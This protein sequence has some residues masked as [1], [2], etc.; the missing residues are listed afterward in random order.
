MPN[1]LRLAL[2]TPVHDD[3]PIFV[4]GN[5][6]DWH[7]AHE[8]FRLQPD[9]P[10]Q[11]WFVFPD[12]WPLPDT[13][14]YKYTKGGWDHVELGSTGDGVHNRRIIARPHT[15]P[16]IVPHWRWFGS[17]FNPE[18]LPKTVDEEFY[19]PQLDTNRLVTVLLPHDY[20]F[21]P[22][23]RYP[24][25]YLNDRQN[26][27]GEGSGYGSWRVEERMALLASRGR[28]EVILVTVDHGEV[29]RIRDYTIGKTR[30]GWGRGRD[31]LRFIRD[32]LKPAIDE[33]LRTLPDA[34]NT[35]IGGSSLGGLISVYGG[36]MQPDVFGRLM[37][38]SPSLWIS[39]KIYFDAIRFRAPVPTRVFIYGGEAESKYMIP[40]IKRF[41][42]ALVRQQYSSHPI[43]VYLSVFP[44][45]THSEEH[46]SREFPRAIEWLFYGEHS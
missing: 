12:D 24:V 37:V 1:Q 8:Q 19:L 46:W 38:F 17:P 9:G 20:R 11:Y 30:A 2:F 41:K 45:G 16:D 29:D 39:P 31:Y 36:I 7:P 14:E 22:D 35:G 34:E 3:R 6:N 40:N 28:H 23:K 25:L 33:R 44:D 21:H 42:E 15:E 27:L 26:L 10:G 18:F 43:D 13:L 4:S 5:F 32:T